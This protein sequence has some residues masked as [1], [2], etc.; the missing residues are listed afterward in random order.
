MDGFFKVLMGDV[1][2][3]PDKVLR[4]LHCYLPSFLSYGEIREG[5]ESALSHPSVAR[6]NTLSYK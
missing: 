1:K 5:S 3:M 2:L 6:V 4:D